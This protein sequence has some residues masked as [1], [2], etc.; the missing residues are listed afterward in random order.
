MFMNGNHYRKKLLTINCIF[1][2]RRPLAAGDAGFETGYLEKIL[3]PRRRRT[4]TP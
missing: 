3:S 1:P 4:K 2:A